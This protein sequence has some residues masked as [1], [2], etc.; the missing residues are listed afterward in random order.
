[1]PVPWAARTARDPTNRTP[2]G[3]PARTTRPVSRPSPT[4]PR[5]THDRLDSALDP[6]APAADD[7]DHGASGD[8]V[9]CEVDREV[10]D[11]GP[12]RQRPHGLRVV[13]VEARP[14]RTCRRE[15]EQ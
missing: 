10:A 8:V 4:S 11:G 6:A 12:Q 2:R 1:M 5:R 15:A 3:P 13:D 14:A 9:G 7:P